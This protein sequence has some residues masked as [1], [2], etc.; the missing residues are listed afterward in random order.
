[1]MARSSTAMFAEMTYETGK[2]ER[3]PRQ[4]VLLFAKLKK[5]WKASRGTP[6]H[7]DLVLI[8]DRR[9]REKTA[10]GARDCVF[11]VPPEKKQTT[12]QSFDR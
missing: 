5:L 10:A 6:S 7:Y 8:L 9:L 2:I 4:R 12:S 1:M 11:D 3:L